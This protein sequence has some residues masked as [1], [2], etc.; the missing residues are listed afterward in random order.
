MSHSA[1]QVDRETFWA[2]TRALEYSRGEAIRYSRYEVLEEGDGYQIQAQTW[3][4]KISGKILAQYKT[5]VEQA[6]CV[7]SEYWLC[8]VA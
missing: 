7:S 2:A 4:E 6:S 5:R 3:R 8:T 1:K